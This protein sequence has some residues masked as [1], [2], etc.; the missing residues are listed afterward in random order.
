MQTGVERAAVVGCG[1]EKAMRECCGG[2]EIG[3]EGPSHA[4][5]SA[6]IPLSGPTLPRPGSATLWRHQASLMDARRSSAPV[7]VGHNLVEA[8]ADAAQHERADDARAVLRLQ[9]W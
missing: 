3:T 1:R 6:T 9:A 5:W 2:H 8:G 4:L 7:V